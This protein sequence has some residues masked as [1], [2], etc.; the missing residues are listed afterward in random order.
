MKST[1]LKMKWHLLLPSLNIAALLVL[2]SALLGSSPALALDI[3]EWACL[4]NDPTIACQRNRE[5]EN[6][7][8]A[9]DVL[10]AVPF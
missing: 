8:Y 1:S 4:A 6:V 3:M 9:F 7:P 5:V 2:L 10:L